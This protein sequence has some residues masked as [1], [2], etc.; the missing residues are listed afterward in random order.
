MA[1]PYVAIGLLAASVAHCPYFSWVQNYLSVLSVE[2]PARFF[3]NASL[4]AGG[5]L[6][7][8][9]ATGFYTDLPAGHRLERLGAVAVVL[10]GCAMAAIGLLPR[11]TGGP[12]DYASAAF[13]ILIPLS[14]LP[15]GAGQIASRK[16]AHGLLALNCG[17]LTVILQLLPWP[18]GDCAISQVLAGLPFSVWLIV[19]GVHL[20]LLAPSQVASDHSCRG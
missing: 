19:S 17:L 16:S 10:A 2:E 3:F 1:S 14:L 8:V 7:V 6:D 20:L 11:T 13:F 12:H 18:W 4:A 15:I 9:F 5:F